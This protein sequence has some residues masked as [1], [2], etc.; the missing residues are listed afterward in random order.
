MPYLIQFVAGTQELVTASLESSLRDVR[1]EHEDDSALL[2]ETATRITS[3]SQIPFAN[4]IFSVLA[5]T[6]RREL[7]RSVRELT[8][9]V[10]RTAFPQVKVARPG[11]RIMFHIDGALAS[12]DRDVRADLEREIAKRTGLRLE[13]RGDG[14][15]FWVIGRR[16]LPTLLFCA[17]LPKPKRPDRPKGSLSIE[18]AG[19]LVAA[20]R[21]R[22]GETLLDPFGGSGALIEAALESPAA[23]LIYSDTAL[24]SYRTSLPRVVVSNRRVRTLAEDA[25]ELTSIS[26][27]EIDVI[28]TDPPWGEFEELVEPYD[29]F[30]GRIAASFDRILNRKSGRLVLLVARQRAESFAGALES[31]GFSIRSRLGVL[32]NG[33]PAVVLIGGR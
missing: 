21:P 23:A 28:V 2:F 31:R 3:H 6:R 10:S 32:V 26:D 27:G 16:H 18:L 17:R 12:V 29:A 4:N 14:R 19:M 1:V 24:E 25:T 13:P 5:A 11:F 20:A 33:H 30:A 9:L 7:A 8:S 22:S 15:E